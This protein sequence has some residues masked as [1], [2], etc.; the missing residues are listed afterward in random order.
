MFTATVSYLPVQ[1]SMRALSRE[2]PGIASRMLTEFARVG[3]AAIQTEMPRAFDRPT[4][5]TV[6]RV[7]WKAAERASLRSVVG[8]PE[9]LEQAGKPT[10]E[11]MRPGVLGAARRN[12]KKT[13]FLLTKRGFLPPGWVMVPGSFLKNKLDGYGNVP[14]SYYKQVIRSLQIRESGDRYFKAVS[15]SSQKRALSMGVS[16]EFLAVGRGRN[17][18]NKGGGWLPPGVYRRTGRRG[19]RLEQYFLFVPRASYEER[20]DMRKVVGEQV[21]AKAPAIWKSVMRDVATRVIER[22]GGGRA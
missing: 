11:Y 16:S 10:S 17:T 8:I 22:G 5:F 19:E 13:E 9:S 2:L 20:L 7:I 15:Q 4:P 6:R 1:R 21:R 12:Q 18:L 3:S 14:G